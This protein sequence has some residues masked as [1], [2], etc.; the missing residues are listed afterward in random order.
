METVC[1]C[2]YLVTFNE[3]AADWTTVGFLQVFGPFLLSI[4]FWCETQHT[5]GMAALK[6]AQFIS[7][8]RLRLEKYARNGVFH[9]CKANRTSQD[10]PQ[11]G[12]NLPKKNESEVKVERTNCR[13]T[14]T[15]TSRSL[16]VKANSFIM[17]S[18]S[19]LRSCLSNIARTT[20]WY[21]R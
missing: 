15:M 1:P 6:T 3:S 21:L 19:R 10:I 5:E 20:S 12:Y 8:V 17:L 7:V 13:L 14:G 16:V 18:Y 11:Q 4:W 9:I 2:R